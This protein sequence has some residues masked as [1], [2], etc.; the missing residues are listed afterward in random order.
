MSATHH[1]LNTVLGSELKKQGGGGVRDFWLFI[2]GVGYH[3]NTLCSK[4]WRQL[5]RNKHEVRVRERVCPVRGVL[6]L[7]CVCGWSGDWAEAGGW[8]G[9]GHEHGLGEAYGRRGGA[10]CL[11]TPVCQ[12]WSALLDHRAVRREPGG[13]R[14]ELLFIV[15]FIVYKIQSHDLNIPESLGV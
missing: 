9:R 10:R 15:L 6:R 12:V 14:N 13:D 4:E 5:R 8:M 3:G 7:P 2:L 11:Y 1:K